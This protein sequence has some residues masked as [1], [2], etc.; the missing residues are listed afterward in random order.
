MFKKISILIATALSGVFASCKS[1]EDLTV[2]AFASRLADDPSVQLIDVRTPEEYDAGHIPG[3]A[4][5]DWLADGFLQKAQTGLDKTRPVLLYCRSGKR[6]A[7]ASAKLSAAGFQVINLLGG[8]QAWTQAAHPRLTADDEA[9]DTQYSTELLRPGIPAP[10]FT[11][12]DLEG[13]PV[14]LSDFRGRKVVLVFWASWCPDCRAEV[15]DLKQMYAQADPAEVAFVSISYDRE[16]EALRT[17]AR[18]Q[19][20]PGTQ[21]FD[22]AGKKDSEVGAA[23]G[24]KWI[25]SLYLIDPDGKVRLATVLAARIAAAL[26]GSTGLAADKASREPSRELCS[27]ENC[28]LP[29]GK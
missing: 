24:V 2:D 28:E 22:P 3:A 15:P 26:P 16:F 29:S 9:L 14:S 1:Y 17:F 25:P 5:I 23:F 18:E 7:A 21:L 8:Y 27:D 20:L 4:N 11:L 10:D 19:E 13:N 12:N 6:S